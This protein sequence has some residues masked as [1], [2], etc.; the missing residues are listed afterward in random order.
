MTTLIILLLILV[1]LIPA[2][3]I[4]VFVSFTDNSD[5]SANADQ[6]MNSLDDTMNP[7]YDR[8]NINDSESE[9]IHNLAIYFKLYLARFGNISVRA[10][11]TDPADA[12]S[13]D[14]GIMDGYEINGYSDYDND[15][16]M[17][18]LDPDSDNDG[19]TDGTEIGI[20][21]PSSG[22]D[23]YAT[24][25]GTKRRTFTAD[26]YEYTTTD[27][28]K[29]DSDGDGLYDGWNDLNGNGILDDN[30]PLGEDLNYNGKIDYNETDPLDT[31]SDDDGVADGF[32]FHG[33]MVEGFLDSDGDGLINALEFD[34]DNDGV[35]DAVEL[36]FTQDKVT[37]DTDLNQY[38]FKWDRDPSTKTD[39]TKWDTDNDTWSDGEEDKNGNGKYEPEYGEL[40]PDFNDYDDDGLDDDTRDKDDDEDGMADKF[41]KLFPNATNPRN[42]S[43]TKIDCDNDG[44]S[45][46]REYLGKDNKSGNEDWSDPTDP[47]SIPIKDSD[48]DGFVDTKDKFPNNA[49]EWQDVDN[50]GIGD[51]ADPD[52]DND[53]MPDSWELKYRLNSTDPLDAATDLDLD[54]FTNL[55]EYLGSDGKPTGDDSTNPLNPNS[56][57]IKPK[58]KK[59][60]DIFNDSSMLLISLMI[61][62]IIVIIVVLSI[63]IYSIVIKKR[64]KKERIMR[65]TYESDVRMRQPARQYPQSHQ[66]PYPS[67]LR[68]PAQPPVQST[69]YRYYP[70]NQNYRQ[71]Q[72]QIPQYGDY[73]PPRD[74]RR[75]QMPRTP[76]YSPPQ[77]Q[78]QS[79]SCPF[80]R[81]MIYAYSNPCP[82]CRN[83]LN[84]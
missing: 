73:H 50:D 64:K 58:E 35:Y 28:L 11:G 31:D 30:E 41:E 4:G 21:E 43:D 5:N 60:N 54:G 76:R 26:R 77:P 16:L 44:F 75:S 18:A 68:A 33:I 63:I 40:D 72:Q 6:S 79:V 45:N 15:G 56:Y 22:T 82:Y 42:P 14:D 2:M 65:G 80:C 24:F 57:P 8:T 17:N 13:D 38:R 81:N 66:T 36:G 62:I 25:P 47:R 37:E 78:R 9:V 27:M 46:Y 39:M 32:E 3:F 84:W 23:I 69:Q 1:L 29:S 51:N 67:P 48:N 61:I 71:P 53:T 10:G 52:D 59:E 74:Y 19:I 12:D 83:Y 34:S 55:E 7:K 49:T 70:Q 20:T